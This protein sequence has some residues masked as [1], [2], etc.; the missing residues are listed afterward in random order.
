MA[1]ELAYYELS[2]MGNFRIKTPNVDR[3]ASEGI[4]FTNA[5]AASP[6]CAPLRCN[7]MTGKHAGNASVRANDG[8]TPYGRT[9]SP[10]PHPSQGTRLRHRSF[11]KWGVR[12]KRLHQVRKA[13]L[14]RLLQLQ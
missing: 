8:G 1:D 5:L 14:W 3:F 7:L 12:W 6:V 2:H 11:G 9:R 10:L 13:R 4:R